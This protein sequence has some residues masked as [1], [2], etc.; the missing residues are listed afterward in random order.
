[1]LLINTMNNRACGQLGHHARCTSKTVWKLGYRTE[2][3]LNYSGVIELISLG[4]HFH[5]RERKM[6]QINFSTPQLFSLIF[7]L[8]GPDIK[9]IHFLSPLGASRQ[10][11]QVPLSGIGHKEVPTMIGWGKKY[12]N[13]SHQRDYEDKKGGHIRQDGGRW[14]RPDSGTMI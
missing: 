1:M 7:Q 13:Q 4:S 12:M 9:L 11:W 3:W 6:T 10:R 8:A 5:Q 2:N 14:F